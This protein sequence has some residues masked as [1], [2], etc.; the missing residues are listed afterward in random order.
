MN[1]DAILYNLAICFLKD[2]GPILAKNIIAY[3]GSSENLFSLKQKELEKI[4]GIGRSIAKKIVAQ[5]PLKRAEEELKF[6]ERYKIQPHFFLDENYPHRLKH[7]E[8]GP[9]MLFSKGIADLN[10]PKMLAIVGTRKISDY[11]IAV[12]E[13]IIT[14]FAE[15][16]HDVCIVSGLAYG[17]DICAHKAALLNS[18]QTIAVLGHGL[19]R[20]YPHLHTSTAKKITG[21]GALLSEFPSGTNPD[22]HN[23]V[24]RNRIIAGIS[25]ATLV[26]ES[27]EKGG[28]LIT[29]D[30]ANSYNRDVFAIPGRTNDNYSS[31]CNNLIKSNRA[32]LV[33][34]VKDIEYLLGWDKP[35]EIKKPRQKEIFNQLGEDEKKIVEFLD[36]EGKTGI[37]MLSLKTKLSISKLNPLLLQMEFKGLIRNLPGNVYDLF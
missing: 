35:E 2:I 9:L 34:N 21:A 22:R 4:P 15:R 36:K 27:A 18:L 25:D 5:S 26:I 7:C 13:K 10:H 29:A 19:D 31:G 12:C 24:Q 11:G 28:A 3:A 1:N 33:E 8:D 30:L 32:A 16:N 23:F 20:I 37:N 17:V 14:E 6:I